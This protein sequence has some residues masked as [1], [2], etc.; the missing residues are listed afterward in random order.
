MHCEHEREW[1]VRLTF[2]LII[3]T[4]FTLGVYLRQLD[5]NIIN[6]EETERIQKKRKATQLNVTKMHRVNFLPTEENGSV[7]WHLNSTELIRTLGY[8]NATRIKQFLQVL[9]REF[10]LVFGRMNQSVP[11]AIEHCFQT[12]T[13][14]IL[15]TEHLRRCD[16]VFRHYLN[17]GSVPE[18]VFDT[19]NVKSL[20]KENSDF[21]LL[22]SA[23]IYPPPAKSGHF[24]PLAALCPT[25]STERRRSLHKTLQ[26]WI[27]F[28]KQNRIMW[29]ICYGSL[30]GSVRDGDMIPY[31]TDVDIM[32]LGSDENK[33][34]KAATKREK[35]VEN[36]FNLVTRP[37]EHCIFDNGSRTNCNGEATKEQADVCSFCGPLARAFYSYGEHI[38]IYLT[39]LQFATDMEGR[40]VKFGYFDEGMQEYTYAQNV[41]DLV[42]LFPLKTCRILGLTVPCPQ[43]PRKV[44][45]LVYGRRFMDPTFVCNT[46][47]YQ[48]VRWE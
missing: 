31:D 3:S 29:W 16:N 11:K 27:R 14:E 33:L 28:A 21:L 45:E 48:W 26:R 37:D 40:P 41:S 20:F 1:V 42:Y 6:I 13:K 35:V 47:S 46:T 23:Y 25:L 38:D 18:A 10:R 19:K 2:C 17:I 12:G 39:H 30:L 7:Y 44:L 24:E 32:V 9:A 4:I 36:Q 8:L 34:R 22:K 43:Q 5:S 15:V